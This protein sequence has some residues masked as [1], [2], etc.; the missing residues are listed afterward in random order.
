MKSVLRD[1]QFMPSIKLKSEYCRYRLC[2]K[3]KIIWL[4]IELGQ[5][6]EQGSHMPNP[7]LT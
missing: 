7:S 4:A 1:G 6:F 5:D 3:I 2:K